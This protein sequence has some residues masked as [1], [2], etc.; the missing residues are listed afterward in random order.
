MLQK[1][2]K[3]RLEP[4]TAQE[5]LINKTI[6][7]ARYIYNY[8]LAL[9]KELYITLKKTMNYNACSQLLTE[10]KKELTWLAQV[11]KFALQNAL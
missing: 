8:F 1:S 10:L 6:G 9:R 4:C 3:V 2:Y 11:D 7:C 5:V